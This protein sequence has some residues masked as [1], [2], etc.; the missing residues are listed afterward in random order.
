MIEVMHFIGHSVLV[1]AVGSFTIGAVLA[2]A[3]VLFEKLTGP[4]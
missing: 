1:V 3:A 4:R 2:G